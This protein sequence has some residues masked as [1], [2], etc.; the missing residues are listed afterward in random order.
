VSKIRVL[1]ANRPRLMREL[2]LE[3][4]SE[5]PDIEV[6]GVVEDPES[7]VAEVEQS[8]PDFGCRGRPERERVLPSQSRYLLPAR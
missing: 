8:R 5:Q 6:I 4:I 7:L 3:T 1:V 2:V